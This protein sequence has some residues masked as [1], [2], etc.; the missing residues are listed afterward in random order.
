MAIIKKTTNNKY[1]PGCGE[2]GTLMHCWWGS[3]LAQ[4]LWKTV[5]RFLKK[6]KV[7]L[8]YDPAT[9]LL[10]VFL[11]KIKALTE[12]D[13]CTLVLT[14]ALFIIANMWTQPKCSLDEWIK[15][16]WYKYTMDYYSALKI[17]ILSSATRR[18]PEGFMLSEIS[19]TKKDKYYTISLICGI[20]KTKQVNNKTK[21]K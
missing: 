16:I 1:C 17:E 3:K 8:Q 2:K 14:L 9:L 11:K 19:Q 12:K 18:G 21:Y 15:K 10:G 5:W 13:M 4:L 7:E 20:Y 6:L